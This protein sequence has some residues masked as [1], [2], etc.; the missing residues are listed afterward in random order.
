MLRT[1]WYVSIDGREVGTPS[2]SHFHFATI[3]NLA[4]TLYLDQLPDAAG[5]L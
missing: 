2:S 3:L 4:V 5:G 1:F